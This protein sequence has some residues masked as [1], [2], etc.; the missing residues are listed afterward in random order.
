VRDETLLRHLDLMPTILEL[1]GAPA[2]PGLLGESF[3]GLLTGR[4]GPADRPERPAFS[5]SWVLPQGFETPALSVRVGDRKLVR[6]RY[7]G[8]EALEL[9]DLASDPGERRNLA[10]DEPAERERLRA[11][12][13]RHEQGA[14]E[15]R[16][17]LGEGGAP[18]DRALPLDPDREEML[19]ILG[20]IE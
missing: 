4:G 7:E 18:S 17:A 20:Y 11:L 12:L 15:W 19:R 9:Y 10:A 3:A 6:H 8:R 13:D 5:A 2:P 1:V 16:R 14:R